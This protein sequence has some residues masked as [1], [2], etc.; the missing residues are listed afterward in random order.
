[1]RDWFGRVGG[2]G[3]RSGALA[4]VLGAALGLVAIGGPALAQDA[5]EEVAGLQVV[6]A[7]AT[8][9][10]A[11]IFDSP[12]FRHQLIVTDAGGFVL[13]LKS[14]SVSALPVDAIT[15]D[16]Q[17]LPAPDM[18]MAEELG[19]FL[20]EEGILS[21]QGDDGTYVVQPEPPLV[22]EI[23]ADKLR[24]AKPDYVHAAS[25]YEPNKAMIAAISGVKTP[26]TIKVFF[27]T[28]CSYCKHWL[29]PLMKTVEA[30]K[31]PAI[32]LEFVG[33]SED[34]SEPADLLGQYDVSLTPTFVILQNGEEVGRFEE[35]PLVSVEADLARYLGVEP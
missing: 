6:H 31:N 29:P 22:G 10:L 28:W 2:E 25:K 7:D 11:R 12:D 30:A 1:M 8:L 4:G 27:G 20:N 21:F 18:T 9:P 14:K 35:E 3:R 34:Q 26:T 32:Q 33:M 23:S 13:D 24:A 19:L 16:D 15:W 17:D 5:W